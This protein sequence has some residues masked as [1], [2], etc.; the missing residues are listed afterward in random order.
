MTLPLYDATS[1]PRYTSARKC[2]LS[3]RFVRKR[4]RITFGSLAAGVLSLSEAGHIDRTSLGPRPRQSRLGENPLYNWK[5]GLG[6]GRRT[7]LNGKS[8]F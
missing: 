8:Q 5:D 1:R 4:F 6:E 7:E 3:V 2:P